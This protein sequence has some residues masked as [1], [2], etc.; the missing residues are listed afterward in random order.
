MRKILVVCV[1]LPI[2]KGH[3]GGS[4]GGGGGGAEEASGAS[5]ESTSSPAPQLVPTP[6]EIT[7]LS[8]YLENS[9]VW[10][11]EHG[12]DLRYNFANPAALFSMVLDL[13][14]NIIQ[15]IGNELFD[16]DYK[17]DLKDLY[18]RVIKEANMLEGARISIEGNNLTI[19]FDNCQKYDQFVTCLLN[20]HLIPDNN[21][22]QDIISMERSTSGQALDDVVASAVIDTSAA[23]SHKAPNPFDISRGPQ[24]PSSI[25]D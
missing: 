1:V 11:P 4:A 3:G 15:F 12:A 7:S 18:G 10:Q 14:T 21:Y 24:P 13:G 20:K 16:P 6:M 22:L 2:C 5:M 23:T 17:Q 9:I 19:S 8:G 25:K